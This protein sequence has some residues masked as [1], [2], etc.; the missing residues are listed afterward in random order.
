MLNGSIFYHKGMQRSQFVFPVIFIWNN[1][2]KVF[3][4]ITLQKDCCPVVPQYLSV[5]SGK[6][7]GL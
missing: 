3:C 5:L 7:F 2:R 4:K 1:L 6:N